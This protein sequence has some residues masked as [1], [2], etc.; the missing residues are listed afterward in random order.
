MKRLLRAIRGMGRGLINAVARFPLAVV[1]LAAAAGLACYVVSLHN[2]PDILMQ[3]LLFTCLTGAFLG[4]AAQF[5]CERFERLASRRLLA[6]VAAALLTGAYYL[7]LGSAPSIEFDVQIRTLVA[8]FA[9]F[10][11]SLYIPSW[12]GGYDFDSIALIHCKAA[13]TAG[14]YAVVLSAGCASILGTIDILL[15][16]IHNEAYQYTMIIIWILFA[17][18][19]YLSLLPR[20]NSAEDADQEYCREAGD[21]PR[22]LEILISYIAIPLAA[23]YTLVL[24]AYFIKI[25]VTLHWP[26]GQL[27]PMVLAYSAAGLVIYIL[28]GRL[29]NRAAVWYRKL[30]PKLLIPIVIMQLVSVGIRLNAFGITESRYY[31]A[32]FGIYALVCAVLLSVKPVARNRMIVLLAAV[33]AVVSIIPP[34]DA[35]NV[36][37]TSQ[38]ARLEKMLE[39]EGVLVDG[40]IKPKADVSMNLRMEATDI[41]RY[42]QNRKY[43]DEIPWLPADFN[44]YK[45]MEKTLGF[46]TTYN[47]TRAAPAEHFYAGLDAEEEP[48]DI[49]GYDVMV[50]INS[51][52]GQ[53]KDDIKPVE[54]TVND[55]K[56]RLSTTRISPCEVRVAVMDDK[57]QELVGTGLYDFAR[58]LRE[59]EPPDVQLGPEQLTLK[60]EKDGYKLK[61]M[62]QSVNLNFGNNDNA[63][64]DYNMWIFFSASKP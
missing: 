1:C 4:M 12:R 52:R 49:A 41:L 16:N 51:Y 46:K 14:V 39:A 17:G 27:G 37:R 35:F 8:V 42:L 33:F 55:V 5:C 9:M 56:Y 24:A 34:V 54:F 26:V 57:G 6:Y 3:K 62:F 7:S 36:S 45:D 19:Y 13:L 44:L 64:A 29:E 50:M 43:T 58:S 21:Y 20:F 31:V 63:E 2:S 53:D 48:V 47:T 60:T 11:L 23:I 30:F 32:L 22:F 15:F 61:I 59:A 28:A 10:C 25:L 40:K 18:L 38:T